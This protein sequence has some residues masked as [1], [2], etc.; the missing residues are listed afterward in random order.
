M[1]VALHADITVTIS[2]SLFIGPDQ[3]L[4]STTIIYIYL[5]IFH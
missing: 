3:F 2:A 1:Y 5:L 4:H